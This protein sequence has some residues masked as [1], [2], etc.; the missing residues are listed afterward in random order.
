MAVC[1]VKPLG[2]AEAAVG[3]GKLLSIVCA[4]MCTETMKRNGQ[5]INILT[6]TKMITIKPWPGDVVYLIGP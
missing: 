6:M 2:K 4:K 5:E 1:K 3:E